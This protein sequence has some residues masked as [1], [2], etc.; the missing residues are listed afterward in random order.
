M[1]KVRTRFRRAAM[2]ALAVVVLGACSSGGSSDT[3]T[4]SVGSDTPAPSDTPTPAD[5]AGP[6]ASAVG[7]DAAGAAS[8]ITVE[9]IPDTAA[10][11]TVAPTTGTEAPT[12]TRVVK[13]AADDNAVSV[14]FDTPRGEPRPIKETVAPIASKSKKLSMKIRSLTYHGVVCGFTFR[15]AA[16]SSPVMIRMTGESPQ[17]P[18]DSGPVE[19]RWTALEDT[20][21]SS[22]VAS[23]SP[24]SFSSEA[25]RDRAGNGWVVS[26]G[27]V[28]PLGA[29]EEIEVVPTGAA[30]SI[31]SASGFSPDNGPVGYWAGY[32]AV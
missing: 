9:V 16:P 20:A 21:V 24:W 29:H 26:L 15:G 2:V 30:C 18:F 14:F 7:T 4:A 31:E 1:I 22:G 28:T 5:A 6:T 27:G 8:V 25:H 10:A 13:S 17:G 11:T 12:T 3:S 32:A 23:D 19:V